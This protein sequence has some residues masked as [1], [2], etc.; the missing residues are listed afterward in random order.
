MTLLLSLTWLNTT[1]V[2]ISISFWAKAIDLHYIQPSYS[3]LA[4]PHDFGHSLGL[5][6]WSYQDVR[7]SSYKDFISL[8]LQNIG[9]GD[10]N[11]RLLEWWIVGHGDSGPLRHRG[12]RIKLVG[13]ASPFH[14]NSYDHWH[15]RTLNIYGHIIIWHTIIAMYTFHVS[16]S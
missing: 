4:F 9:H 13:N 14:T 7:M 2:I 3:S 10:I 12:V 16:L 6:K 1:Q 5:T 11:H 15:N 8:K